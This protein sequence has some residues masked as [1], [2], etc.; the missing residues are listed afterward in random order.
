MIDSIEK[1]WSMSGQDR[2]SF[3]ERENYY[4]DSLG[5][6]LLTDIKK[7]DCWCTPINSVT[8]AETGGDSV[9]YG[10]L[11]G[12]EGVN[13][14]CPVI[15]TLPCASN[16]NI[17]IAESFTEFLSLGCRS[18]YCSIEEIEYEPEEYFAQLDSHQYSDCVSD[19][20]TDIELLKRIEKEFSL[21][22]WKN[23]E[24]RMDELRVKYFD[25]LLYSA[26]YYEMV[27]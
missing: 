4:F 8:F 17:I 10:L 2:A 7:Y 23:H 9:H 22:P 24:I 25:R 6:T 18:G 21:T 19:S 12:A 26:E 20:E 1:L 11:V 15:M 5:L 3:Q 27:G 14:N 13:E 16:N